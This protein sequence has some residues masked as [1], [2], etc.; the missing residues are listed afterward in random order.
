MDTIDTNNPSMHTGLQGLR[1][2]RVCSVKHWLLL[3]V[4]DVSGAY[5]CLEH[6]ISRIVDE[7]VSE[8]LSDI[9]DF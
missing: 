2:C 5:E 7:R 8:R 9:V 1:E 3:E 4:K 6:H